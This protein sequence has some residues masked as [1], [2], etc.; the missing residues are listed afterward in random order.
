MKKQ[1]GGLT[2]IVL[3]FFLFFNGSVNA[4]SEVHVYTLT[5]W[6]MTVPEDGS[7]KELN[8]L[9]KEWSDKITKKNDKILSEKV[10]RHQSGS[11]SRDWLIITEYAN[12]DDINAADKIQVKLIDKAWPNKDDRRKYFKTFRKYS[13]F[14]SDEIMNEIPSLTK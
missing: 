8:Q 7:N 14:H 1:F 10:L 2:V 6:K 4:Q 5:T 13:V 12:W 11:D 3:A 9:F